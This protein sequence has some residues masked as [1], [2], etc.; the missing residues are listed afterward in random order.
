MPKVSC[1]DCRRKIGFH[2]LETRTVAQSSGFSTN[3]RCP[4]CR[5]AIENVAELL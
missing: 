5:N 2:E 3:Y 4:F 1:P